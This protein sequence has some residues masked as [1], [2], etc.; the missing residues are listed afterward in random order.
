MPRYRLSGNGFWILLWTLFLLVSLYCRPPIPVDET[1]YLSVAWEMWHSNQFLVPHINGQ[2]YSHKPPLLFWLIQFG[3]WIFGVNPWSARLTAPFFCFGSV[4]LTRKLGSILW[5]NNE[6]IKATVPYFLLGMCVWSFY[7]TLTMF[8]MLIAFLALLAYAGIIY[9]SK[10][11]SYAGWIMYGLATGLGILAKGPV[12]LIFTVPPAVL[13]CWWGRE[14]ILSWKSWYGAFTL[15]LAGGF[16]LGLAWAIPAAIL[17]GTEYGNA[18]L[19]NQTA[20]RVVNSFAHQRPF[21]W[22][23]L[24]LP[25]ITFP[26]FFWPPAWRAFGQMHHDQGTRLCLSII[27]PSFAL[28]SLISGKQ[29]HYILPLLPI[30]ALLLAKAMADRCNSFPEASWHVPAVLLLF[31]GLLLIVPHMTLYGGDLKMLTTIPP[32]IGF[33]P[34]AA[35]IFLFFTLSYHNGNKQEMWIFSANILFMIFLQLALRVPLHTLFDP[36]DITAAIPRKQDQGYTVAVTPP[37]LK[38]QLHFAGRLT[39]PLIALNT[40]KEMADWANINPKQY[41]LILTENENTAM[42]TGDGIINPYTEGHLIF[43]SANN[44]KQ[45]FGTW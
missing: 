43:L 1:R 7:G 45:D 9:A 24:F 8:D 11:K 4:L 35:G 22:Y 38:D 34:V 36:S 5:P 10:G 30:L 32:W 26:W 37:K 13:A 18:I 33:I 39:K 14:N 3:W 16:V 40:V 6:E 44:F 15:A 42:L 41:C 31:G 20:G 29:I 27:A 19:F 23:I 28:L 17:G 21:Y 25:L 12:I 2:P